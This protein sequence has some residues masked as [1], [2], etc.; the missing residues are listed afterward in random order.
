MVAF[1]SRLKE[2]RC[3]CCSSSA[4]EGEI[5]NRLESKLLFVWFQFL[6]LNFTVFAWSSSA[7]LLANTTS[8]IGQ[9]CPCLLVG[10]LV[11]IQDT[12]WHRVCY[13]RVSPYP[14]CPFLKH[15]VFA[16]VVV[17]PGAVEREVQP[18]FSFQRMEQ[19]KNYRF[20]GSLIML[21]D[22]MLTTC[23]L[24]WFGSIQSWSYFQSLL[25]SLTKDWG[26]ESDE[27]RTPM[28]AALEQE[29]KCFWAA[30]IIFKWEFL[31]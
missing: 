25:Y 14:S 1:S 8:S 23:K 17:I 24:N 15:I 2:S 7:L 12:F 6:H 11:S 9:E 26:E 13:F 3:C 29:V 4:G 20:K 22:E 16:I 21:V 5:R 19:G 27:G 18:S 10:K 28:T 31:R 30:K